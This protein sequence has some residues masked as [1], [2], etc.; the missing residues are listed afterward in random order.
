MKLKNT[1]SKTDTKSQLKKAKNRKN[2]I[3]I[4]LFN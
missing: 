1:V 2:E 3:K 4:L